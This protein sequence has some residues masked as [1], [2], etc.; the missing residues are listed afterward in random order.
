[1]NASLEEVVRAL[2]SSLKE[3]ERLREEN[4]QLA[5]RSREPI[6]IVGMACR[7]PGG[8]D[9]PEALWTILSEGRDAVRGFPGDRGWDVERLY[10]PD[11]DAPGKTYVRAGGFLPQ[12]AHFDAGF[13]GISPRE[14]LAMDPQQRLLLESSWEALEWAGLDVASLRGSRTGVY[15][16]VLPSEYLTDPLRAPQDVQDFAATGNST[17]IAS[18]RLAYVLGLEGPAVTVDTACS[19]SLVALHLAVQGLRQGDCAL[20]LAGGCTVMSSPATIVTF[21][22]QRAFSADGRC[23]AFGAAADGFGPAEGAGVLVLERLSDARRN[24]HRVLAV[25]RGSAVNQ[26][27]ASSGLTAP[28]GPS[29]QRVIR[30]ALDNAGLS[31]ADVDAVEAHGTGTRLGDPIEAQALLATYGAGRPDDRPVWLG[32]VKSNIGHTQAAAG[33]AGVIK[34]VLAMRHE[35]LPRTLWADE[36]SPH[37]DWDAGAVRLLSE[38][39]GWPAG[40]RVRRAGVSSFGLS[41]TNAHVVIEEAPDEPAGPAPAGQPPA[42][43]AAHS[44]GPFPFVLSG[45]GEEGLRAQAR[46]LRS[47]LDEH[48]GL[49]VSGVAAALASRSALSHRAAVVAS[50]RAGLLAGL[51]AIGDGGAAADVVSGVVRAASGRPGVVFVFPGQG[52]QWAGMAVELAE[53][54]PVFAG[55]LAECGRALDRFVDWSLPRVLGDA[56][57]LERVDVVQPALWAVMVSLAEVWRS[58]GVTP[59]AVVG[60]SQGEIAAACVAGALSLEDAARVVAVRSQVIARSLAGRGGMASVAL[61]VE[62]VRRLLAGWE[63]RVEVAAVNGPSATVVSGDAEAIRKLAAEV[64]AIPADVKVL[65]V[66]YASH[67][68]HVEAIRDELT[69]VLAPVTPHTTDVPIFSTVTGD[70]ADGASLDA[71]YWYQNLRRTVRFDE[72]ARMF[73][74]HVMIECSPH[75]VL[76]PAVD[77]TSVGSLSRGSGGGGRFLLSVAEAHANGVPVD[78]RGHLAGAGP[79]VDLPAYAFQRRR[80]WVGGGRAGAADA[81]DLGLSAAGHPLLGAEVELPEPGGFLYTSRLS[82]ATQPWLADHAVQGIVTVPATAFLELAL[83]LGGRL[84]RDLV[85]ELVVQTPLTL[86]AD[87]GDVRLRV[88]VTPPDDAG[89]HTITVYSRDERALDEAGWTAHVT[90]VLAT[91]A[92]PGTQS[93]TGLTDWP[94]ASGGTGAADVYARLA[95]Q[96]YDYGPAL[97]GLRRTWRRGEEIFA[98]A[99]LPEG[100]PSDGFG[101]HPALLDAALHGIVVDTLELPFSWRNI[102]LHRTGVTT[103]RARLAP[104]DTGLSVELSDGEGRPVLT[105]GS[106]VS[107]PATAGLFGRPAARPYAIR[108]ATV[109]P[110]EDHPAVTTAVVRS[111]TELGEPEPAVD[112]VLLLAAPAE[113]VLEVAQAWLAG[114]RPPSSRLMVV[115]RNAG[116]DLG[117]AEVRGLMR[118]AI[119]EHPDRFVLVDTDDPDAIAG[120]AAEIL[121]TGEPEVWVRDGVFEAPRLRLT[122]PEPEPAPGPAQGDPPWSDRDRVL[123][124]GGTGTVGAALARHLVR[125]HGVRRL[126]L[127]SR[128][129]PDA[130]GAAGLRDELTD[131]LGAEVAVVACDVT[132]RDALAAV[133]EDHPVTAVVHAAAVLDDGVVQALTAERLETVRAAKVTAAVHLHE[134]TRDRD[135]TAFVLC[136]S[137]AGVFG[138]PGQGNYAAANCALDALAAARRAEGLPATSLAWGLWSEESGMTGHRTGTDRA[139]QV[140]LGIAPMSTEDALALFDAGLATGVGTPVVAR[141]DPAALRARAASAEVPAMLR[142]L[143]RTPVRREA[144][145]S[146]GD[147]AGATGNDMGSDTASRVAALPAAERLDAVLRLVRDHVAGILGHDSAAEVD[148]DRAFKEMGFDSLTAVELRNRLNRQFALR[149]P[150]TLVFDRPTPRAV[151]DAI[152]GALAAGSPGGRAEPVGPVTVAA[153]SDE[154]IAVV[155]MSCRFPGGVRS[156]EDLWRLVASGGDAITG[157][158]TDRGW[159]LANLFDDDPDRPGRSYVREGGFLTDATRFDAG[160]FGISPREATAMDPQQRLLLE[161]AWEA[162][163]R[164][165]INPDSVRGSRTGVFAGVMNSTYGAR[166]LNAPEGSGEYEGYLASGFAVSV[167][168]G[169]VAYT[170]GLEG[171]ALTVDTACSSSLVALHLAAQSLRRGECTLALAGGVTVMSS[172]LLF[173]EFSRQRGL[174]RDGRCKP[175]AAAADGTS[176]GEGAGVLVLERLSDARRNGHPVLALLRGSAVNQDG[177]SNG[178]SS[179]NGPS[180]QRVINTALADAGLSAADVDAVEAHGTG[181]TLGDPIEAQALLATYG[182]GRERPLLLGSLKS[183]IGHTQAASGIGGVIKMV[184]AMRHGVLPKTL[185]VDEPTP[186]VDWSLGAVELL[187]GHTAW[188]EAGRPRRAGVSAFGVSGTNAHVVLEQGETNV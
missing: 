101:V 30:D 174:A 156:P 11:P 167:A 132:E 107:R 19:S 170:L 27:G 52:S 162:L 55:R 74:D 108:P 94:P 136:S 154:P 155:G 184:E 46:R 113:R 147:V 59:S 165:G 121:A 66:D 129:G 116:T 70:F 35:T 12:A 78:W 90:G 185:H 104:A 83:H 77:V 15:F 114:E 68:A 47:F 28:N 98:E 67:S 175:F 131:E 34:M 150:A 86:P 111:A 88:A 82:L 6:A 81:A 188:P 146:G 79:R 158:P 25:V 65:P 85:E 73:D 183:N 41:G 54:S 14:A 171:P 49:P 31:P 4:R 119:T 84:G 178:L 110:P 39:R 95:A 172:P 109:T 48:E 159:D 141:L 125:A 140:R 40:E 128:G 76:T 145:A 161:A 149:L 62:R 117:Q 57:A 135:L 152:A 168:S 142:A 72:A 176:W 148:G 181:T 75:P 133:L 61:P 13:F 130:P 173:V 179:P 56:A 87:G 137:V 60:H 22:R 169:R 69:E 18:G 91:G 124:T 80:Y 126:V 20:A 64:K 120:R 100:V 71:E 134:L 157:F 63:G 103:L 123:I 26:D 16:G 44:G 45:A 166:Q 118:S 122:E 32:S 24:G 180:Q 9:S 38:E 23:K 53:W 138:A 106:L 42:H 2:R 144:G 127:V 143:V 99:A 102:A 8:A 163:E 164:A 186:N 89:R 33:V 115:T 21:S 58:L 187:T 153:R 36:P 151:A 5:A 112:V 3:A 1:M 105:A 139:R 96:G 160:F 177:A 97:R 50:E 93:G 182:Q 10:D 43:P 7:L 51:A 29:Q 37:I 17:S 92:P